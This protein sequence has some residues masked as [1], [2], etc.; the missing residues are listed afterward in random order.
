MGYC[1][2]QQWPSLERGLCLCLKWGSFQRAT[3]PKLPHFEFFIILILGVLWDPLHYSFVSG[4]QTCVTSHCSNLGPQTVPLSLE[5][6]R[7]AG[8]ARL[9][10]VGSQTR[11]TTASTPNISLLLSGLEMPPPSPLIPSI[12]VP[13]ASPPHP[14]SLQSPGWSVLEPAG[15]LHL[16]VVALGL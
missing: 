1:L 13:H 4:T 7:T 14:T 8:M 5:R 10:S 12:L 3:S 15:R 9:A 16:A 11:M 6:A 2:L